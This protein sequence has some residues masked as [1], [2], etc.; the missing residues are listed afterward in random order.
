MTYQDFINE[1][2]NIADGGSKHELRR[3]GTLKKNPNRY[4]WRSHGDVDDVTGVAESKI[5]SSKYVL[6]VSWSTGG[7]SGGSCWDD[8]S[9]DNHHSYTTD[10]PPEELELLDAILNHFRPNLS[11]LEY[12]MLNSKLV[13]HGS[14]TEGEYYGNETHYATKTVELEKLYNYMK[15]KQWLNASS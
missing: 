5:E 3:L 4:S 13:E 6:K 1:V 8:G 15:E 14:Y 10:N 2:A 9:Q 11:F 7:I 12:K